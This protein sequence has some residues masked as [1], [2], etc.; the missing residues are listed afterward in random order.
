[1][2][3]DNSNTSRDLNERIFWYKA[4]IKEPFPI[5]SDRFI[6]FHKENY[7]LEDEKKKNIFDKNELCQSKKT[8]II[9]SK[10]KTH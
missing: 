6:K 10:V 9:V 4:N 2:I 5:G 3:I 8:N 7:Q 1:M